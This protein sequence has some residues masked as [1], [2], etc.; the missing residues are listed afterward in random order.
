LHESGMQVTTRDESGHPA[1][2]RDQV[3]ACAPNRGLGAAS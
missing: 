3:W 2:V 1:Y